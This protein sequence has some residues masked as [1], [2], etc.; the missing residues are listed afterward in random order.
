MQINALTDAK[1]F[2]CPS[3]GGLAWTFQVD[4][5]TPGNVESD[6]YQGWELSKLPRM[7]IP[8][9]LAIWNSVRPCYDTTNS[10]YWLGPQN[11]TIRDWLS[12]GGTDPNTLIRGDWRPI[13]RSAGNSGYSVF[14]E[15]SYRNQ[16]MGMHNV[17]QDNTGPQGWPITIVYTSPKV[18]SNYNCPPFKTVRRLAGRAL[19]SDMFHKSGIWSKPGAGSKVHRDGYNVLYGA[20]SSQWYGDAEARIMW[21][22][23]PLVY[24]GEFL[25]YTHSG[26]GCN[27]DY[28][29]GR[30]GDLWQN[31]G[32]TAGYYG[33][34]VRL[35]PEVWHIFDQFVGLDQNVGPNNF[36]F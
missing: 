33:R 3:A 15:Y 2:Y 28:L 18:T 10:P 27:S 35:S 20:Y 9:A 4:I 22:I 24:E 5:G 29:Y 12:A 26:L 25:G 16:P 17:S 19:A 14:T 34:R 8:S 36:T 13:L 32:T 1:S 11:T 23:N 30:G 6:V 7:N 31:Y 21:W